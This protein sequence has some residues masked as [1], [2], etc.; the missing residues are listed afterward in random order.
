MVLGQEEDDV[1]ATR[2]QK[3]ERKLP[4]CT[5]EA[6]SSLRLAPAIPWLGGC[7]TISSWQLHV[8]QYNTY[9]V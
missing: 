4:S 3:T 9:V 6:N 7:R 1:D 2:E 8:Q 5:T